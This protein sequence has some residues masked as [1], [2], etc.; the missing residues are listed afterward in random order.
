MNLTAG[1]A[2][3]A[4][5]GPPS[6]PVEVSSFLES[7]KELEE[8]TP[9]SPLPAFPQSGAVLP[10]DMKMS[11]TSLPQEEQDK[12]RAECRYVFPVYT[13]HAK[14]QPHL[15]CSTSLLPSYGAHMLE[16]G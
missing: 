5:I 9:T 15:P 1:Q 7:A 3:E 4:Y 14:C 13:L 6:E 11:W 8:G 12:I 2:H 10:E 16:L